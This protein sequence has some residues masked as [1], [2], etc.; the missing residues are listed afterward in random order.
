MKCLFIFYAIHCN[1]IRILLA[2]V[3][4][5]R[6]NAMAVISKSSKTELAHLLQNS[7]FSGQL[8]WA[9]YVTPTYGQTALMYIRMNIFSAHE[10]HI[11]LSMNSYHIKKYRCNCATGME[12]VPGSWLV[13]IYITRCAVKICHLETLNSYLQIRS[14]HFWGITK[15]L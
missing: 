13:N 15:N 6:R 12:C 1:A 11:C 10:Y 7:H 8:S 3:S 14:E 2:L 5:T 4:V 9:S